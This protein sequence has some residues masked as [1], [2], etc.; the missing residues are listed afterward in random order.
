MWARK[1]KF[2]ILEGLTVVEYLLG[3][4]ILWG[5]DSNVNIG[6]R[7]LIP[8][9]GRLNEVVELWYTV[10]RLCYL[11]I[12]LWINKAKAK[13]KIYMWVSVLWKTTN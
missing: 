9:K 7:A 6:G 13:D 5:D 4:P 2:E 10:L 3:D 11:F 8:H 1:H 12:Y